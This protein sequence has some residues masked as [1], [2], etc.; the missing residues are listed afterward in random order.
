MID[1]WRREDEGSTA[2]RRWSGRELTA[3]QF[4]ES[5]MYLP[6]VSVGKNECDVRWDDGAW[7][8]I[9]LEGGE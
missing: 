5:V 6:V 1:K 8:G 3:A 9:N 2:H 7:L 4:G